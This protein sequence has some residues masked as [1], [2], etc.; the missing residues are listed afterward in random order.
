MWRHSLI[1]ETGS[2]E[3]IRLGP[4]LNKDF[5]P[6]S[7][8][9][10]GWATS[11]LSLFSVTKNVTRHICHI[12]GKNV[13]LSQTKIFFEL[14]KF[15]HFGPAGTKLFCTG[16]NVTIQRGLKHVFLFPSQICHSFR[17]HKAGRPF[18][19]RQTLS[20][21]GFPASRFRHALPR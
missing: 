8:L 3:E 20:T 14:V 18:G 7:R 17:K 9:R 1:S 4:T 15:S 13:T 21:D 10:F 16:R 2:W 5:F 6:G 11:H 12:S 19:L